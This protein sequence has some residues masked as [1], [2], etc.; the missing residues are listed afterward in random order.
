MKTLRWLAVWIVG[1]LALAFCVGAMVRY[2]GEFAAIRRPVATGILAAG[3]ALSFTGLMFHCVGWWVLMRGL[4]AP[5]RFLT[6]FRAWTYSQAVKYVPGKILVFVVRARVCGED[7]APPSK[8]FAGAFLE[9]IIC[10]AS[11]LIIWLASTFCSA[12]PAVV[13]RWIAL[14]ALV[15]LLAVMNPRV[16]S[17]LM[18]RY[19]KWRNQPEEAPRIRYSDILRPGG[20]YLV[21]WALWGL[22]GYFILTSLVPIENPSITDAIQVTGG[23]TFAWTAGYAVIISPS[24]LGAR[25][26]ALAFVLKG[27]VP[28]GAG[29]VVSGLARLC[30]TGVD[31]AIAGL[32]YTVWLLCRKRKPNDKEPGD[33]EPGDDGP[34]EM[35]E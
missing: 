12:G 25:E 5:L 26:T 1:A 24:G 6:A 7:G 27:W 32:G 22:G 19:Y 30:H 23:F 35:R 21:G 4:G 3:L 17:A 8:V 2:W 11:A 18:K 16:I 29:M 28:L 9:I 14:G 13:S 31:L 10:L 34:G 33:G 20:L 15:A